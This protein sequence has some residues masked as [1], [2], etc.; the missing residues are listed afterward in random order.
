MKMHFI[1]SVG[2]SIIGNYEKDRTSL[3]LSRTSFRQ[4]GIFDNSIFPIPGSFCSDYN[5]FLDDFKDEEYWGAEQKSIEK[6]KK[7][8]KR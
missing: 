2:T 5:Y 8:S 4:S 7:S 1:V 6:V 3:R